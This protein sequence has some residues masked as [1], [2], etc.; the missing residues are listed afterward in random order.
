MDNP[1]ADRDFLCGT[2]YKA[3][4]NLAAR[5]SIYAY[6]RPRIDLA[7]R[8][9]DLAAPGPSG[10]IV[11]V[12]CGNGLYLAEL[13]R[14]GF[15]GRV[16]GF[17]LS[18]GMLAAARD[19]LSGLAAATGPAASSPGGPSAGPSGPNVS[20]S[21]PSAG[22]SG[23]NVSPSGPNVS[24]GGPSAGGPSA[25]GPSAGGPSAG[26]PSAGGPS[27]GGPSAGPPDAAP[28]PP[29]VVA[30]ASADA[31]ALPLRDGTAHLALAMHML[32]H[33]PEPADALRELR[34]V[35]RPGGRVVIVLNGAGHLRELRA[36]VATA[37]G[38]D[39]GAMGERV[40]LDEGE[41]M[42]RSCFPQVTRHDFVAELRVP[43]PDLIAAYVRSMSGTSRDA[44]PGGLA[45]AVAAA[46]PRTTEGHYAIT[47]H[48]GS[49][50][51]EVG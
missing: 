41:A 11:D 50:I 20:P 9:F 8:V 33:V 40:R 7:A 5:Q 35:T 24:A 12:G 28:G 38:T 23:P 37:R 15:G 13:A 4:A 14:R 34:R 26:G 16:L 32:Y 51:C 36:A 30:L 39:P 21:G 29:T 43:S 44:D 48:S 19:R 1:W 42:A 6:Q 45:E 46:F 31:T 27:A 2:Q 22:P 49:L 17:D 47:S 18:L 3:D 25:G 10:T